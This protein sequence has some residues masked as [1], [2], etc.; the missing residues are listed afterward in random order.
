MDTKIKIIILGNTNVGKTSILRR[1]VDNIFDSSFT[2][3]LGVDFY[4]INKEINGKQFK[5]YIWDT[6]GQEKFSAIVKSYFRDTD[7]AIIVFDPTCI[8]SFENIDRWINNLNFYNT[9]NVP[10]ILAG[11]KKDIKKKM[12]SEHMINDISKK[13]NTECILCSSKDNEN[14]DELFDTII[15]KIL[16][17]K[18][19]F[20][21]TENTDIINKTNI[22]MKKACCNIL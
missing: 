9:Y 11:T 15:E 14:I 5:I 1:K 22:K 6:A 8:N 13:Y 2:T 17:N 4:Y 21:N 20:K 18:H 10:F 7:G 3:T 16:K 12:I 19:I